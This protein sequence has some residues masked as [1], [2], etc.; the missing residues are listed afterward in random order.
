LEL[1]AWNKSFSN[2][3]HIMD[4]QVERSNIHSVVSLHFLKLVFLTAVDVSLLQYNRC[5]Q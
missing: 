2:I 4:V 3:S 5:I 1:I